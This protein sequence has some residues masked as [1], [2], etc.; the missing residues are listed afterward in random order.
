MNRQL[1][2]TGGAQLHAGQPRLITSPNRGSP[3]T[4]RPGTD[5]YGATATPYGVL[6]TAM[7]AITVLLGPITDTVPGIS[8]LLVT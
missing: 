6:P 8:P 2:I 7:V 3:S 1:W 4:G 5:S